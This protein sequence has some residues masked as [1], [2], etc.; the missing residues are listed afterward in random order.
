M[1]S[2]PSLLKKGLTLTIV[3]L[4]GI[5]LN[6]QGWRNSEMEIKVKIENRK[7]AETLGQLGLNGDIYRDYA[8]MYVTPDELKK[9]QNTG[10][11]YEITKPNLNEYY[12]DFWAHRD[13][14]HTYNEII[15]LIDSLA[16]ALPDLC[17][18]TILGQSVGGRQLAA[19]K[20]SDN[21]QVDENEPEVAMDG[22]IHGDEIGGGENMIRFARWLCQQ[23]GENPEITEL[24]NTREIWIFPLVNPDGR[25]NLTRYNNNGIDLNRDAGYN[26]NGEGS[27]PGPYSQ[28]E[29]KAVR[30]FFYNNQFSIHI[31]YHSGTEMFLHPWFFYEVACPDNEA[32]TEIAYIYATNSGYSGL[33]TG[34]GTSLYPTTGST[35]ESFYGVMGSM[36]IVMELSYDKQ[37][38]ASQIGYYF[39]LNLQ[40]MIEV[41]KYSGYGVDGVITDSQTGEPVAAAIFVENTLPCYSDPEVGDFHKFIMPGTYTVKVIANGYQTKVINNVVV[42]EYASTTVNVALDPEEHQGIYRVCASQRPTA[43]STFQANAWNML[44]QPDNLNYPMGKTG[45]VVVDMQELVVDGPGNDLI[46]FEGDATP[47]GFTL[48]AGTSMDGPWASVGQGTGTTEFD[49][50]QSTIS[51]ARYFK[52]LDD[53]DGSNTNDAGFELDAVQSLSSITGVYMLLDNFIVNDPNGNGNGLLDPGETADFVIAL[54]NIGTEGAFNVAGTLTSADPYITILTIEPQVYGNILTGETAS[55]TFTVSASAMAPAGHTCSFALAYSGDNGLSGIKYLDISFRDYCEASTSVEDEYIAMVSCGQIENSSGWQGGVA[56]YTDLSTSLD[57]GTSENI[58]VENGNA[59]ASDIVTVWIDW[60]R[61]YEFGSGA[62]ETFQLTNVGGS[63]QTFTG[64]ISAPSDAIP[65]TYRMRIRMT[66]STAPTPCGSATY[67]EVEDYSVQVTGA[68]VTAGFTADVTEFCNSGTVQFTDVSSGGVTSWLWEFE[69]GNPATS[70][71]QNPIVTYTDP[72][73]YDVSLT[74]S[75]GTSSN[76]LSMMDYITVFPLPVVT[77]SPIEDQCISWPAYQLVEG[78][79]AGGEYSGPGVVYGLFYPDV[80]GLGTHTLTYH[81]FDNNGCENTAEQSVYVDGCVGV[82]ENTGNYTILPNPSDGRFVLISDKA[83]QHTGITILNA[84]G[85]TVL[86]IR[87]TQISGINPFEINITKP[88]SGLYFIKITSNEGN[89]VK[90]VVI[91]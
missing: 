5:L 70:T 62:N 41:L 49:L 87:D 31:T 29:S 72:S 24:V 59:W 89:F 77:F 71:Q 48:Y 9:V 47:E 61:D 30:S 12:N 75:N 91:N 18:K 76:T 2:L 28:P 17:Q 15:A 42:N 85:N 63:G 68:T 60:D 64:N 6:A 81:Y 36:G 25:V 50:S 46:V 35:A 80:A 8:L 65:G 26:W 58:T 27:S 55:A 11:T 86:E 38:P 78:S 16:E 33:E 90:K 54:K 7:Q 44:G 69:G 67:G 4:F 21:V 84:R 22:N 1:N 34:P 39:N 56:N 52:I 51:E 43:S 3:L 10:L 83:I 37:P 20:I 79:P 82:G 32:A 19:L 14:Y 45:W 40:S 74:V 13:A 88:V 66:Y 73:S 57:P 23:Y 53:G